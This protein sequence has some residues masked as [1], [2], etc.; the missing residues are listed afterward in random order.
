LQAKRGLEEHRFSARAAIM[1]S[2][3]AITNKSHL[4]LVSFG[5]GLCVSGWRGLTSVLAAFT[6]LLGPSLQ[7]LQIQPMNV[8]KDRISEE[9]QWR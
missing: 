2:R 3:R 1:P 9:R 7:R 4:A 5:S 6:Q 8:N